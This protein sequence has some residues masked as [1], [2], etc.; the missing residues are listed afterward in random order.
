LFDF[1]FWFSFNDVWGWFVVIGSMDISFFV[2]GKEWGVEH[3]MD[4]P[5]VG[6]L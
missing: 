5:L 4:S 3:V 6:E 2:R 1:E